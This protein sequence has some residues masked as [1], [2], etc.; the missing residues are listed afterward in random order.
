MEQRRL[1]R[2]DLTVSA[3]CLGTMTWGFQNSEAEGHAQADLALERGVNFWDTAEMYAIPPS[4]ETYGRTEEIIGSW[5]ASRGGRDRIVLATKIIGRPDGGFGWIREGRSRLDRA[6]IVRAVEDSLRRLRTDYIDLYQI[7]W[8]DRPVAKFGRA[9]KGGDPGV[10][11][12]ET[13]VALTDLVTAG[14]I[15]HIGLSNETAWGTMAWLHAAE[16]LG[17]PRVVSIQNAYNLLNRTF[18]QDLAEV[19]L[20]EDVGLLAYSPMGGGTLSGKYLN[21]ALPPGSRRAIDPRPSRYN[22]PRGAAATAAYVEIAR[23]H[24]LD[25][26]Q[27]ALAWVHR[28]PFVTSS[29]FGATSME[30]LR[31][32]LDAYDLVL[33]EEVLAEIE[34]VHAANPSPCP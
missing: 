11:I 24:G 9:P 10:P 34:Q 14:K 20:R 8:P 3:V 17:L 2:T 29:I 18:E 1:G 15:R 4:A 25:P 27:M 16:S 21:G 12:A 13:L 26:A 32:N 30:H 5:F 7:H 23:R 22:K 33:S 31:A 28:R 19:S 6:N